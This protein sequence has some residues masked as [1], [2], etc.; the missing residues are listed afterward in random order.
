MLFST[1]VVSSL[2][3]SVATNPAEIAVPDNYEKIQW[4]VGNASEGDTIF[5]NAGIYHEHVVVT[6]SVKLLGE[7][8]NTTII[9]GGISISEWTSKEPGLPLR[10]GVSSFGF[11]GVNSHVL[12]EEYSKDNEIEGLKFEPNI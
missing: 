5:V 11:G 7:D 4:A 1:A 3:I 12:L 9:D 2:P 10:A 8:S 6:K